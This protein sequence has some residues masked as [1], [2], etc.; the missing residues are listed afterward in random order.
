MKVHAFTLLES[1][2]VLLI[3]AMIVT[4]LSPQMIKSRQRAVENEFFQRVETEWSKTTTRA[5]ENGE[6]CRITIQ[7]RRMYF[8]ERSSIALPK[9]LTPTY[10]GSVYIHDD[11]FVSPQT[12]IFQ[13][14]ID[15]RIYRLKIQMGWGGFRIEQETPSS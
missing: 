15:Q 10:F 13:S 14:N 4:A 9:T 12:E 8:G 1:L 6:S 2:L 3:T 7:N 5:R 11:G